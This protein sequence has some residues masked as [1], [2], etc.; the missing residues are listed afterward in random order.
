MNEQT[1]QV[2]EYHEILNRTAEHAHTELGK[3]TIIES[4]PIQDQRRLERMHEE[5]EEAKAILATQSRVPLHTLTDIQG[6]LEQGK[7][8]LYLQPR[9]LMV[10]LS[11]LDHCT[12]LK[13]FMKGQQLIAPRI[14]FYAESMTELTSLEEDIASAIRH[15]RVDDH[16]SKELAKIRRKREKKTEEIKERMNSLAKKYAPI[17]QEARPMD[18]GG[19]WTLPVK[20]EQRSKMKGTVLDQSASGA[21][22]FV[23]PKEVTRLQEERQ[24]LTFSEEQEVEQ[25]LYT[26]TGAVLEHEQDLSI[27][28]E[29]MHQY[30]VLFAKAKYSRLTGAHTPVFTDHELK[31]NQGRHPM[32]GEK[33]VPLTLHMNEGEQALLITGPNTGGKTVTLKTVGLFCLMAQTGLHIPAEP[34]SLL[35]LYQ[36]IYVDIGDGQSIEENLSTFSSRLTNLIDILQ[37]ANDHS[38]LLLDEIGSGTEP[39]EG[40]GL[41]TAILDQLAA[42]GSDILATTHYSEMKAYAKEKAGFINGAMAFDLETLKPTYQ[43]QTGTAGE[44]QAFDIAY[45]LGL[46]PDIL[47]HAHRITYKEE[48]S[49]KLEEEQRKHSS[50][51]SQVAVNRYKKNRK[52]NDSK[53][54]PS[55]KMGDN[56]QVPD[57]DAAG[58]VYT[59]PDARG[60]Y[61]VQVK[62][63]KKTYN[64]K[65]LKL[66]IPAEEL[67]PEDYDFDIIFKS[68]EYRK[69][70]KM[71]NRKY[72]EGLTLEDEE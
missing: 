8:G 19:R 4:R 62:G 22:L 32:L 34:G 56:V 23:E 6:M 40:M 72:V 2:L 20:R 1:F 70:D 18:K 27:A 3:Q 38:L 11:F 68:K 48:A 66:H 50:Y 25:I 52:R 24:L 54:P 59:G 29:T 39:G 69:I 12:K 13:R 17:M 51:A 28:V 45:K 10:L 31:I 47:N 7:K 61:V 44:S 41:A 9:Q 16:A 15:A 65:R 67:Y 30:D 58:I 43:L 49:Y 5:V 53:Q 55:F 71:M 37:K 35:P 33:A 46:H 60:N 14:A 21:T 64:H 63:E 26:L 57:S 36:S 42:K